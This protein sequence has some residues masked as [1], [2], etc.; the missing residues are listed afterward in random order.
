MDSSQ[1]PEYSL[2]L[3]QPDCLLLAVDACL[4]Q[5]RNFTTAS[6]T[7]SNH[8]KIEVSLCPA[9]PP[10][11]SRIY[12][13]CPD[14]TFAD[15][16][17]IRMVEDL[18]LLRVA[19]GS[20][21]DAASSLD[22]SDYFVYRAGNG[23]QPTLQRLL[24]PHPFFHDDD[25]GLLSRRGGN[26][27]VAVLQEHFQGS[28][29]YDLHILHSE[30]PTEWIHHWEVSV[31]EPQLRPPLVIPKK[32][33]RL[34]YYEPSTVISIGGEAGT[35]GWVDLW[36]GILLCDVLRDE[37]TLRAVPVPVPL[38]LVSCDNGLG[39][40]LGS[41]IPFRGIA[42]VKGG[43]AGGDG[44][45]LKLVH[46]VPKATLVPGGGPLS[47]QMDDWIIITYT[48]TAMTSHWKD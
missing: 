10:L 33:G 48:N 32:C 24:R 13:H 11:P 15:P 5:H 34:L 37:P 20:P 1:D 43:G 47:F 45:C 6:A 27:T 25:V 31:T 4:G 38:D 22:D 16:G 42:F 44:D 46:L 39:T 18:F 29:L 19:V 35:I 28:P 7:T 9:R 23:R 12:V 8:D 3:S 14:L 36:H 2:L 30:N 21:R 41:P 17:V 40:E 26:Y